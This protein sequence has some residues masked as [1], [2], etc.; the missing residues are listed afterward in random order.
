MNSHRG[1]PLPI[2][3]QKM[4]ATGKFPNLKIEVV[5]RD[6]PPQ[7]WGLK[8]KARARCFGLFT[9]GLVRIGLMLVER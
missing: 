8:S 5:T 2:L 9:L 1:A 4:G 3:S 7:A 6:S